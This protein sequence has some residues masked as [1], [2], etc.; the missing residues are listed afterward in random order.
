LS[1]LQSHLRSRIQQELA[2]I[3]ETS[4]R[5]Q[6]A[7]LRYNRDHEV[8]L[9]DSVALS[10]HAAYTGA[11]R[12]LLLIAEHIDG[13]VP[14]GRKWH[15]ALVAQMAGERPG[16]RPAVI[17]GDTRGLLDQLRGFRHLVRHAYP[18][19]LDPARVGELVTALPLLDSAFARDVREF[20]TLLP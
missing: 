12:I 5:A 13:E 10:A 9:L 7:W 15:T 16:L 3:G 1:A 6:T 18:D 19:S 17:A 14:Q 4:Q 2:A 11:E 20:L 8:L